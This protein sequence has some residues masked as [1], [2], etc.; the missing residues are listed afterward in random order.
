MKKTLD[1]EILVE[2]VH[3]HIGCGCSKETSKEVVS[4]CAKHFLDEIEKKRKKEKLS[5]K[6]GYRFLNHITLEQIEKDEDEAKIYNLALDDIRTIFKRYTRPVRRSLDKIERNIETADDLRLLTK[7]KGFNEAIDEYEKWL[8]TAVMSEEFLEKLSAIE[9][10]RWSGWQ[11]YLHTKCTRN[12]DGSLTIPAGYTENLERLIKTTY[13]SLTEKEKESD[14]EE[15]RKT[16]EV[17]HKE[18][19][20]RAKEK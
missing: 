11:E 7:S 20:R 14:R 8:Q 15:A 4:T 17:I 5:L 3:C 1:E 10:T 18:L 16:I 19:L 9:H 2:K 12:Q 6:K 13:S